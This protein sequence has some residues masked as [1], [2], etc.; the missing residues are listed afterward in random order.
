VLCESPSH[1][2]DN[3]TLGWPGRAGRQTYAHSRSSAH[4]A[5]IPSGAPRGIRVPP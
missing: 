5:I 4:E 2:C 3:A 1:A